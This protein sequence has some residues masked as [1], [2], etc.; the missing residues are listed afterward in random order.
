MNYKLIQS[1]SQFSYTAHAY[2]PRDSTTQIGLDLPTSTNIKGKIWP[3][4]S[5]IKATLFLRIPQ[6]SPGCVKQVAEANQK[7]HPQWGLS[8]G[9][10]ISEGPLTLIQIVQGFNKKYKIWMNVVEVYILTKLSYGE[11]SQ[12][13][14][15]RMSIPSLD[16]PHLQ[17][18]C[19]ASMV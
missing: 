2:L 15:Y 14:Q 13:V 8:I 12:V 17:Q 7:H 11:T 19:E 10:Q 9:Q 1:M 6:I 3:Q 5:M 18:V 16:G 4:T